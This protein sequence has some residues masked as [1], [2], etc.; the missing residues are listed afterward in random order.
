MVTASTNQ[1]EGK[2]KS[3]DHLKNKINQRNSEKKTLESTLSQA[4]AI[5]RSFKDWEEA[6]SS[7]ADWEAVAEKY[8]ESEIQRQEPLLQIAAEKARL[9]QIS[10][11]LENRFQDLQT[12]LEKIPQ[13]N[14]LLIEGN[15]KIKKNETDLE[16]RE[17]KKQALEAARQ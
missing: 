9:L 14:N 6:Q 17:Q 12:D 1:L 8:R 3:I 4:D 16:T 13:L 7:L 5:Q 15:E 2:E 10:S 11:S